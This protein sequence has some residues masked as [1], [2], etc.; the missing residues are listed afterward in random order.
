MQRTHRVTPPSRHGSR[1]RPDHCADQVEEHV[2]QSVPRGRRGH[3][4][5][6]V[7]Q[8]PQRAAGATSAMSTWTPPAVVATAPIPSSEPRVTT[9]RAASAGRRRRTPSRRT[10]TPVGDRAGRDG[11]SLVDDHHVAAGLLH[12][13]EQVA[14]DHHGAPG[15]GVS[16]Q[17]LSHR[18]DLRRIEAVRRLVEDQQV[19]Q[20]QHRLGDGQSLTHAMGIRLDP[21]VDR[22]AEIGDLQRFSSARRRP[23]GRSPASTISW[24]GP[25]VRQEAGTFDETSYPGKDL[26]PC[27]NLGTEHQDPAGGRANESHHHSEGGG[28]PRAVRAQEPED[29]A[30]MHVETHVLDRS[31]T[32]GIGLAQT[33]DGQRQR[34][35]DCRLDSESRSSLG[36]STAGRGV[37]D[38]G[39]VGSRR[40]RTRPASTSPTTAPI[41]RM[42]NATSTPTGSSPA[43]TRVPPISGT[44]SSPLPASE[45]RYTAGAVD[46]A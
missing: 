40:V 44:L 2:L 6:L 37:S 24:S 38:G 4:D 35:V 11:A 27:V 32:A 8:R 5:A 39:A 41:T 9:A 12:L 1:R 22:R 43:D 45:I 20:A 15:V 31:D 3:V 25:K 16:P 36:D 30:A 26:G 10:P 19:G 21:A 18:V 23:A 7:E 13:G 29:L 14:R 34:F 33:A 46:P 28:L 17:H 42:T